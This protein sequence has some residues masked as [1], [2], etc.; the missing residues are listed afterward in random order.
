M[1]LSI[2]PLKHQN[3]VKKVLAA[4]SWQLKGR[5]KV[6]HRLENYGMKKLYLFYGK[7]WD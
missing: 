7:D 6:L 1:V 4:T 2:D 3:F 5:S